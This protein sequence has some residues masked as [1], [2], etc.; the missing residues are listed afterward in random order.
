MQ[1]ELG[2][3]L[4][5]LY[6]YVIRCFISKQISPGW[7]LDRMAVHLVYWKKAKI[8]DTLTKNNVYILN[9]TP[10]VEDF[11]LP[12]LSQKFETLFPA[13][14]LNDVLQQCVDPLFAFG[15]IPCGILTSW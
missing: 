6:R 10:K 15:S 13:F 9:P 7:V 1:T 3:P 11:Y 8:V 12:F 2:V 14:R 5:H 4:S